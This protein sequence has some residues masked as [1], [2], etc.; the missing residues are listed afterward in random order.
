M[1]GSAI[2]RSLEFDSVPLWIFDVQ[3]WAAAKRTV[4]R[5]NIADLDIVFREMV[6][7][8]VGVPRL[9]LQAD[10]IHVAAFVVWAT[11]T[12]SAKRRCRIDQVDERVARSQ[13]CKAILA[14]ASF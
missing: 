7:N 9:H 11:A 12:L 6:T 8:R 10:V 5:N 2:G 14:R 3:G 4:T 13:L 1:Q